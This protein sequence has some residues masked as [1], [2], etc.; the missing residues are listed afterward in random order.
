MRTFVIGDIHGCFFSLN[1]LLFDICNITKRDRII[2]LGDYIDRGPFIKETID[3][4]INLIDTGYNIVPIRGNHEQYLIDSLNNPKML[5]NW[6]KNGGESTLN[7][8]MVMNPLFLDDQYINF[9]ENTKYYHLEQDFVC[10]HAGLNFAIEDPFLD[11]KAILNQRISSVVPQ[12]IQG[13]RLIVG[14]TPKSIQDITLSLQTDTIRL[15]GGCVYH[16]KI[17]TLGN[18]VALELNEMQIFYTQ[19][20]EEEKML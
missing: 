3:F 10:V 19:N 20:I 5:V 4:I 16:K 15:D 6:M 7:S 12:K 1:R 9:F 2:L 13:K 8:F 14:H 18:L 11:K 17:K